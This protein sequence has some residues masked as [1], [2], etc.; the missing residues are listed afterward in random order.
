MF[1]VN[2][3]KTMKETVECVD[4][5]SKHSQILQKN[6]VSDMMSVGDVG[7]HKG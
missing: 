7:P 2:V 1:T 5:F 6:D 4:D 3:A